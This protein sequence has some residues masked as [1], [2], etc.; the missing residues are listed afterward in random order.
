MGCS[1]SKGQGGGAS[2][3]R[4]SL[5]KPGSVLIFGDYFNADTRSIITTLR[6]CKITPEFQNVNTLSGEHN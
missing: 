6:I 5:A 3:G 1:G 2:V 4:M